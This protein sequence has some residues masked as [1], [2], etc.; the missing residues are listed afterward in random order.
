MHTILFDNLFLSSIMSHLFLHYT[1]TTA[2][3]GSMTVSPSDAEA[4]ATFILDKMGAALWCVGATWHDVIR[5]R[6]Y[7]PYAG[8]GL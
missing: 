8:E 7:L 1:G 5:T 4:Q 6:A 2:T 3:H